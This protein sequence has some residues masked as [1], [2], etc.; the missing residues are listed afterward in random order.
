MQRSRFLVQVIFHSLGSMQG[1]L[2]EML[3]EDAPEVGATGA[4]LGS[5]LGFES[6]RQ[7]PCIP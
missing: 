7:A 2:T 4:F 6:K 5:V 3:G 1:A